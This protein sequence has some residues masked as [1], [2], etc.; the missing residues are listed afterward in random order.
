[1]SL[2]FVLI[3]GSTI[4]VFIKYSHAQVFRF[5]N[6]LHGQSLFR[7][8]VYITF[9]TKNKKWPLW[10]NTRVFAF[11]GKFSFVVN[12]LFCWEFLLAESFCFCCEF[13]LYAWVFAFVVNFLFCC[14]FLILLWV[15]SFVVNFL[16][17]CGFFI[18]LWAFSFVVRFFSFLM[19][20]CYCCEFFILL[21]ILNFIL[22][23]A[24]AFVVAVMCPRIFQRSSFQKVLTILWQKCG[25]CFK[26]E[27]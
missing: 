9:I 23:W 16:F 10:N 21:W 17:C 15:F 27:K 18:L 26:F 19:G 25:I 14:E 12:F 11:V 5:I 2:T 3:F 8:T 7:C 1:M 22:L 6:I 13:L 20:F 24:F 4:F